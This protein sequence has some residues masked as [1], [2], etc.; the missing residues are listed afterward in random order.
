VYDA[1]GPLARITVDGVRES[2]GDATATP[3]P[4]KVFIEAFVSY[5]ALRPVPNEPRLNGALD[6]Q[7]RVGG[8]TSD[9][10][11]D[12]WVSPPFSIEGGPE[13]AL[14]SCLECLRPPGAEP[15]SGWLAAGVP[16]A[17]EV[18]LSFARGLDSPLFEVVLR[19]GTPAPYAP[20]FAADVPFVEPIGWLG[21]RVVVRLR[22]GDRLR[23]ENSTFLVDPA[24]GAWQGVPELEG[25]EGHQVTDGRTLLAMT[26]GPEG[27][28]I[29]L[30][31]PGQETISP[32]VGLTQPWVVDWIAAGGG[33]PLPLADGGY[34][35]SG[36]RSLVVVGDDGTIT[37]T[38][39]G[40]GP[41]T[42]YAP[43]ADADRFILR[44]G[45]AYRLWDRRD[46][47]LRPMAGDGAIVRTSTAPDVLAWLPDGPGGW[48]GLRSDG[49]R[50]PRVAGTGIPSWLSPDGSLVI[51][52]DAFCRREEFAACA[53]SIEPPIAAGTT[54]I[55]IIRGGPAVWRADGAA[56]W[57]SAHIDPDRATLATLI[58]GQIRESDAPHR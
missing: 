20:L 18:V 5:E 35:L 9:P 38:D 6:W 16:A 55:P 27:P 30:I 31:A 28:R 4:G 24:S 47:G 52:G 50:V 32:G 53:I 51:R 46:G 49:S 57:P 23:G 34:M 12:G 42:V 33:T 22:R 7:M 15:F 10:S 48:S 43:T 21:E 2:T 25:W 3:A 19:E 37:A 40:P 1:T 39:A 14:R 45:D 17:G 44:D 58:D 26:S 54:A 29:R 13:P 11:L 8:D 56:A 36:L 41:W